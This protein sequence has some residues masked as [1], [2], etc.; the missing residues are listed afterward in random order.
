MFWNLRT[1]VFKKKKKTPHETDNCTPSIQ[2]FREHIAHGT[3]IALVHSSMS[4]INVMANAIS[5]WYIIPYPK[6]LLDFSV[7]PL[8]KKCRQLV[9][10]VWER[11]FSILQE[12][13]NLR[14]YDLQ[15][16]RMVNI[17]F[18]NTKKIGVRCLYHWCHINKQCFLKSAH[19]SPSPTQCL[20]RTTLVGVC[21]LCRL[22]ALTK[23]HVHVPPRD[24]FLTSTMCL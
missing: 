1:F 9:I 15:W 3:T 8:F 10:S 22:M 12:F 24:T 17:L 20:E 2:Q 14:T 13:P 23:V 11:L 16:K 4:R 6:S 19:T 5:N 21:G 18:A 7:I